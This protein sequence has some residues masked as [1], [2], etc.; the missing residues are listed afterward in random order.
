M[1]T[2]VFLGSSDAIGKIGD[3]KIT[4]DPPEKGQDLTVDANVTL[5]KY[6][7][8]SCMHACVWNNRHTKHP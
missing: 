2:I 6:C 8:Y 3:V 1:L 4:P 5:S 7:V